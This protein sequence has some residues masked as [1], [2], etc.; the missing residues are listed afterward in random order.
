MLLVS[1]DKIIAQGGDKVLTKAIEGAKATRFDSQCE[2]VVILGLQARAGH[3]CE[4]AGHSVS[5]AE[6]QREMEQARSSLSP[7]NAASFLQPSCLTYPIYRGPH[8][9]AQQFVF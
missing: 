3:L 6:T 7:Q 4:A 2:S 5:S 1:C 8:R 9:Q